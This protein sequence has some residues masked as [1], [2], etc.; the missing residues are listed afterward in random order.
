MKVQFGKNESI[1]DKTSSVKE[2]EI[3][4]QGTGARRAIKDFLEIRRLENIPQM[5]EE[6]KC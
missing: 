6:K 1:Y 3:W 2:S 4:S 5:V